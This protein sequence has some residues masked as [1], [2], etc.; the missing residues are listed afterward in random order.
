MFPNPTVVNMTHMLKYMGS[1]GLN[2]IIKGPLFLINIGNHK[3][4]VWFGDRY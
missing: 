2:I 4:S 3:A 1:R